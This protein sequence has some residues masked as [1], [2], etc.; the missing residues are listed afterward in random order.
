[1]GIV[2]QREIIFNTLDNLPQ[3]PV[4]SHEEVM[5]FVV[6]NQLVGQGIGYVD[7]CLLAA[8]RLAPGP[9]CGQ[10][11]SACLLYL[12]SLGFPVKEFIEVL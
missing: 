9:P 6:Q 12:Y 8:I 4:A 10:E 7:V 2:R 5:R 3:A 1:M 11:I